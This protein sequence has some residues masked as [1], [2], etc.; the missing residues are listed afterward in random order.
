MNRDRDKF[1][2][3]FGPLAQLVEHLAFNQGVVGSSPT[4]LIITPI[5]SNTYK[6]QFGKFQFKSIPEALR[7]KSTAKPIIE[8][9]TYEQEV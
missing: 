3:S 9:T 4:R 8:P 7:F 5:K 6:Q 2:V 1:P